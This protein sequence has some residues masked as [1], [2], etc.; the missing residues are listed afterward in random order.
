MVIHK[1][2]SHITGSRCTNLDEIAPM[3]DSEHWGKFKIGG[4]DRHLSGF[5]DYP[6]LRLFIFNLV[7]RKSDTRCNNVARVLSDDICS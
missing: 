4:S 3:H 7:E 5:D 1:V 2:K 6:R